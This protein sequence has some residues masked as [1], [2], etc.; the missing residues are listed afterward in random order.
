MRTI[1]CI[2]EGDSRGLI[3]CRFMEITQLDLYNPGNESSIHRLN[4]FIAYD[5]IYYGNDYIFAEK[6]ILNG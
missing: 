4:K 5:I 2:S 6:K 3:R 1:V